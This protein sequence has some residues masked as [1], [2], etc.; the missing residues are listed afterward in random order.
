[1]T[2]SPPPPSP[3]ADAGAETGSEQDSGAGTVADAGSG[4]GALALDS[5]GHHDAGADSG[6]TAL[7]AL[8]V[9]QVNQ[10]RN[11]NGAPPLT[12]SSQLDAFAAKAAASDAQ[13]GNVDGYFYQTNGGGVAYTENEY[14]GSQVDPGGTAE[15]VL[16]QGLQGDVQGGTAGLGNILGQFSSMGCGSAKDSGGQWWV[17]IEFQF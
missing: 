3:T 17:T 6:T 16:S 14:P 15:Q 2:S 13:S 11:Q 7:A 9:S 5:G 10:I 1:M 4:D 8:C 12:E